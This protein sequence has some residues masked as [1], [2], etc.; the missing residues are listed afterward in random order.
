[1]TLWI[2]NWYCCC[3]FTCCFFLSVMSQSLMIKQGFASRVLPLNLV[4]WYMLLGGHQLRVLW[5]EFIGK[6]DQG[7]ACQHTHVI[8]ILFEYDIHIY[9]YSLFMHLCK[10]ILYVSIWPYTIS[11]GSIM[12]SVFSDILPPTDLPWSQAQ[13]FRFF[14][15]PTWQAQVGQQL[16]L[17]QDCI[18]IC[19]RG[20]LEGQSESLIE[21]AG[22]AG[23][24]QVATS[25]HGAWGLWWASGRYVPPQQLF[26]A[27]TCLTITS[28]LGIEPISTLGG[29]LLFFFGG[30]RMQGGQ[31]HETETATRRG[32]AAWLQDSARQGRQDIGPCFSDTVGTPLLSLTSASCARHTTLGVAATAANAM[33]TWAVLGRTEWPSAENQPRDCGDGGDGCL[34]WPMVSKDKSELT[35][36]E[37]GQVRTD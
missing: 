16:P 30:C 6:L 31:S 4:T 24:H 25:S 18:G 27:N 23:R 32:H 14:F 13:F 22:C 29:P 9:V 11:C 34:N 36:G 5:F 10:H 2:S 3:S 15:G 12:R 17:E 37:Q 20:P 19:G 7:L 33:T 1:M 21:A 35:N 28:I 26:W 8:Y